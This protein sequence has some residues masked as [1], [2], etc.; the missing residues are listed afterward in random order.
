[1]N[2][3][4]PPPTLET[5][6]N[7]SNVPGAV[8]I[9]ARIDHQIGA[10]DLAGSDVPGFRR[11]TQHPIVAATSEGREVTMRVL[12]SWDRW[13]GRPSPL[14]GVAQRSAHR[15]IRAAVQHGVFGVDDQAAAGVAELDAFV[16]TG[17]KAAQGMQLAR[18]VSTTR[19]TH[20]LG[21]R[22]R[23]RLNGELVLP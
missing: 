2:R 19:A 3:G 21:A 12:C 14:I 20:R 13:T 15:R 11:S 7:A 17:R 22:V 16:P 8:G 6:T 1:M 23:V 9:F 18:G 10:R 4:V 5:Y